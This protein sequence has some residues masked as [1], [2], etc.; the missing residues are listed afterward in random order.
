MKLYFKHYRWL[1]WFLMLPQLAIILIFFYWPAVQAMVQSFQLEDM[2]GLSKEWVGFENFA[3]LFANPIY[4]EAI[5]TTLYFSFWVTLLG[6]TI[7]LFLAF[8]MQKIARFI[9]FYRTALILPYAVSPIVVGVLWTFMFAPSFG[10]VSYALAKIGITW[11][12]QLNADQAMWLV[13]IASIWK[14]ISYNFLFF[15]AGLQA[16]PKSLTEAAAIDGA[17]PWRRFFTIEFPLLWPTTFFLCVIN[18]VYVFFDTFAII[19]GL[20]QGGPGNATSTLVYR[21]YFDGFK[22]M[23]YGSSAAQSVVL[24]GFVLIL[25]IIQFRYIDRKGNGK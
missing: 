12:H 13:I 14:Q 9:T 18:I 16:I 25:T 7:A 2:F 3:V 10:L 23:N 22:S 1:P 8:F 19:D 17:G 6:L 21:I 4:L 11:N 24:M 15:Y 5:Y 20:T